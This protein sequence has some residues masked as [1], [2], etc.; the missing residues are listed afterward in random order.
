M[1]AMEP[2]CHL[3]GIISCQLTTDEKVLL[4]VE[5]FARICEELKE[6]FREQY[7]DYFR[8]MKFTIEKEDMM[9]ETKFVR[10]IV[11]DI[12]A[13]GEYN[14]GGIAYYTG[15]YEEVIEEL[16]AERNTSPSATFLRKLIELHRSVRPELYQVVIKKITANYLTA[17]VA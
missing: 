5:L 7:R 2:L 6:I 10:L 17:A 8:L 3:F 9:L 16:M 14:L 1:P 4:E 11:Q 15:T 13:T 12:L